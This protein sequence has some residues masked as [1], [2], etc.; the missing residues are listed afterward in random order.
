MLPGARFKRKEIATHEKF[1]FGQFV[2]AGA[3]H[4]SGFG[5][6][7]SDR[8]RSRSNSGTDRCRTL[9]QLLQLFVE[10][11]HQRHLVGQLLLLGLELFLVVTSGVA[12][13]GNVGSKGDQG[14]LLFLDRFFEGLNSGRFFCRVLSGRLELDFQPLGL[15]P[16]DV[17]LVGQRLF[18]AFE[19]AHLLGLKVEPAADLLAQGLGGSGLVAQPLDLDILGLRQTENKDENGGL[20]QEPLLLTSKFWPRLVQSL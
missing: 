12:E 10:L 3:R 18:G 9:F 16:G 2:V 15:H 6:V 14:R 20:F 1:G 17:S 11:G 13:L 4:G 8:S 19:V 7:G 5:R